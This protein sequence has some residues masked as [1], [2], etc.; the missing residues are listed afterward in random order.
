MKFLHTFVI[1]ILCVLLVVTPLTGCTASQEKI[2]TAISNI[3]QISLV[4]QS[5]AY[6]LGSLV[7]SF[8]PADS[9]EISAYAADL[10]LGS[11][12]LNKLCTSYLA[13]PSPEILVKISDEVSKLATVDS[14]GLLQLLQIKN[15]NSQQTA[16][17][18]LIGIAT[19]LTAISVY[20][21]VTGVA[22]TP[23]GMSAMKQLKQVANVNTLNNELNL[24][25][26]Q[27]LVSKSTTLSDLGL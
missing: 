10:Q 19:S 5:N 4:V 23:A 22:V 14:A 3:G 12:E 17:A 16:K 20:L 27:D 13:N 21:S 24:A 11:G 15:P 18:V 9:V 1:A 6:L 7:S 25:K 2:N 8:D 26:S